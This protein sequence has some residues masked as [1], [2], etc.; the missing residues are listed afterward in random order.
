MHKKTLIIVGAGFYQKA[1]VEKARQLRFHTVTIDMNKNAPGAKIADT[2]I[3]TSAHDAEK[4][5]IELEKLVPSLPP[6]AGILSGGARGC[7]YTAAVLAERFKLPGIPLE[8]AK[9]LS[10]KRE[11]KAVLSDLKLNTL[12]YKIITK[13]K[14]ITAFFRNK[15][16]LLKPINSSGSDGIGLLNSELD[17]AEVWNYTSK[18]SSG[19]PIL[20]EEYID[21]ID[22]NVFATAQ[23]GGFYNPFILARKINETIFFGKV[24][25][26]AYPIKLPVFKQNQIIDF[27]LKSFKSLGIIN[28]PCSIELRIQES[29][30]I[31][32]IE[33]EA[34]IPG[35]FLADHLI[36]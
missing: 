27:A 34:C 5:K 9:T 31:Q 35:C 33:A 7:I 11:L 26:Y 15:P 30:K 32:A 22:I 16:L 29:G 21:G 25:M 17:I 6:L 36:P 13:Q 8:V 14:E 24:L 20:V 1:I 12:Q 3:N 10:G 23:N 28:G 2:A 4:A 18:F 19:G